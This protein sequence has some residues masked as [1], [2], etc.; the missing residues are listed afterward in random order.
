MTSIPTMQDEA[1]AY[2]WTEQEVL[3]TEIVVTEE[4]QA[5]NPAP[6]EEVQTYF[7]TDQE[8]LETEIVE[9]E[10]AQV[11][12]LTPEDEVR[13]HFFASL[14]VVE[15]KF[16]ES[17]EAQPWNPSLESLIQAMNDEG[18]VPH[19][20]F[21]HYLESS[22]LEGPLQYLK[23]AKRDLTQQTEATR[24]ALL[25]L[26]TLTDKQSQLQALGVIEENTH[27]TLRFVHHEFPF[28]P[29]SG[30]EHVL[31]ATNLS[32][33]HVRSKK[34]MRSIDDE[35]DGYL[36]NLAKLNR[37]VINYEP[38]LPPDEGNGVQ[39]ILYWCGGLSRR[40]QQSAFLHV[41]NHLLVGTSAIYGFVNSTLR[42]NIRHIELCQ[43][44]NE[45]LEY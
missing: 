34:L 37:Y 21:D 43:E 28:P 44:F 29:F 26:R 4:A 36:S 25:A 41:V 14:E 27:L 22:P 1:Q 11:G 40:Q 7:W 35:V 39:R 32:Y 13:S 6:E 8:V 42:E 33:F 19:L 12:N 23:T 9:I 38:P 10:E 20:A 15:N 2:L 3:E 45:P 17:E 18:F 30:I 31:P 16:V 5:F 24:E